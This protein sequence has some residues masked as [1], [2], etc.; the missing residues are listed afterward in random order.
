MVPSLPLLSRESS[1]FVKENPDRKKPKQKTKKKQRTDFFSQSIPIFNCNLTP[2]I[3]LYAYVR[4]FCWSAQGFINF[5]QTGRYKTNA[6]ARSQF[7]CFVF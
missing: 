3:K 5:T 2:Y 6:D 1:V 4:T 7:C